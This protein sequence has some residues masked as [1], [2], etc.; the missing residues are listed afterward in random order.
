[1]TKY[2]TSRLTVHGATA[3]HIVSGVTSNML[4]VAMH[5][6]PDLSREAK[7]RLKWFEYYGA[8]G[9]NASLTCRYFGIS[10]PTFYRWRRRYDPRD[11]RSLED[12]SSVPRRRRRP[13][14]SIE[15]VVAVREMREQYPC[16]GK[17][18]L[19]VLLR[20]E[21]RMSTS[22]VGK[23]L[24][25]LKATG[26]LVEPLRGRISARKRVLKREYGVRKPKDY[27]VKEP[28]DL[29]Q[30]DTLDVRPVPGVELK[31]FTARDV[32]SKWDVVGLRG[33]ATARTASEFLVEL[34]ERA[35]YQV[36]TI[37][38]DGGSEFMAEF[39]DACREKGIKLFVLPP[40][41]PKLNGCVERAQRTHTEEFYELSF[42]Q[43][44][45]AALGAELREWERVYN[46]V[47][48][49]QSLGYLTPLEFIQ[50]WR[51]KQARKEVV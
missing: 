42:A 44:T 13:S 40:R 21:R 46:E 48:P 24:K 34:E 29:V 2:T 16:W 38:V 22:R 33:R 39:E 36:K 7:K 31:H 26:Q 11:L 10:R 43:P 35:P 19:V 15:D 4:R 18:K 28:G 41:S 3:M 32:V 49:H 45:V 37:Q 12:C 6:P 8:H 9:Q 17:D 14:W 51:E 30:V 20:K 1:M 27:E 50:A 5:P 25:H 47:R 23:I